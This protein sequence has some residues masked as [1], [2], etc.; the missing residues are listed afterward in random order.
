MQEKTKYRACVY[1]RLSQEDGDK[2]ESDSIT[3]Q[4]ALIRD[5]LSNHPEIQIVSERADDGY[6]GVN[7][8][9]PSFQAMMEDIRAGKI[10]CVVVKDLSRFGRNYIESGN[11]IEKVFPFLGVRFIAVNDDYDSLERRHSDSL[12]VPFKNLIND[13]YCKDISVKIRTQLEIKRKK[14][15]YTGPSAVYGYQKDAENRNHLIPDTFAAEIVRSIFR[16]KLRGMS[17]SRIADKLNMEGVLC[18]MEYK[19]SNGVGV[20]TLFR[21]GQKARWSPTSVRRILVNEVY[22][23][24][25]VQGKSA[26]PNYKVK[27]SFPKDK[28]EWIRVEGTHAP[29]IEQKEFAEVQELL[30]KDVRSAPGKEFVYPL[31]GYL[32]CG[33]CGQNLTRMCTCS[34]GKRYE[35]YVCSSYRA[36]KG[37]TSHRMSNEILSDSILAAIRLRIG[38]VFRM[39]T[40]I[41]KFEE[42][43]LIKADQLGTERYDIQ[44]ADMREE[45][46][47]C[48]RFK[49]RLY[50]NLQD[51]AIDRK[52]YDSFRKNYEKRIEEAE[53]V[54]RKAEKERAMMASREIGDRSWME[55]FLKY[56]DIQEIERMTVV[57]L[58]EKVIIRSNHQIEVHFRDDEEYEIL[59]RFLRECEIEEEAEQEE[60]DGAEEQKRIG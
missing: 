21:S 25:L 59:E 1:A 51:G 7:F 34:G 47:H 12:I 56:Q 2:S 36:G 18:P 8:E 6:S 5:F 54:I 37:C 9:R 31:S 45:I 4:K 29:I 58:I 44:I 28:K 39:N 43:P 55:S 32:I 42:N 50:E 26:T 49:Q 23:G 53:N 14:G 52:D 16:W 60:K 20:Q 19:Q 40:L 3:S 46:A 30:K 15:Q 27:K 41:R 57:E 10:D 35:Y 38:S 22:T 33:D 48:Q 11:Y 24:V 17:V 13:A